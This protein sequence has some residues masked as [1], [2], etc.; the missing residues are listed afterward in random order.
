M[1]KSLPS[2]LLFA[3]LTLVASMAGAVDLV[4]LDRVEP[5]SGVVR[6]A[7]VAAILNAG[8]EEIEQLGSLPLMPA[9]ALGTEQTITAQGIRELLDA[10]RQGP[11]EPPLPR[12]PLGAC[13]A[14]RGGC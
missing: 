14:A 2:C 5:T 13:R 11:V 7:D 10:P 9:P 8:P 3:A 12:R 1:S 4:L 6:L